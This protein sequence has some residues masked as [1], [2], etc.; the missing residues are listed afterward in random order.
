MQ[1]KAYKALEVNVVIIQL[2]GLRCG[3][4]DD[5]DDNSGGNG[6]EVFICSWCGCD[7]DVV[8]IITIMPL[9]VFEVGRDGAV[10][11][12]AKERVNSKPVP[13]VVSV[14]P[15]CKY[16]IFMCTLS[17]LMAEEAVIEAVNLVYFQLL[18]LLV[19]LLMVGW[20]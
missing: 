7:G 12:S 19:M 3:G 8:Q 11:G 15:P 2:A 14:L 5:P 4:D 9:P 13:E 1:G 6:N 17:L 18:A 20:L 10:G 16:C